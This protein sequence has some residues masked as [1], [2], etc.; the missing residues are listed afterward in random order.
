M[1]IH[2]YVSASD[3]AAWI[4]SEFA[5]DKNDVYDQLLE[6]D[7]V[8]GSLGSRWELSMQVEKEI[9]KWVIDFLINFNL[10]EIQFKYGG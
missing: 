10:D 4:A 8:E 3:A 7:Y 9:D 2:K 1:K 6:N 5:L